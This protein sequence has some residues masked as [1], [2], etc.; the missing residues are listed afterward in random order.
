MWSPSQYD[1][2][3]SE[4]SQ[5]FFDLLDLVESRKP[6]RVVDLGC[7]TGDL[8][9]LLHERTEALHTLGID[10]SA[11]MLGKA[12]TDVPGLSFRQQSIAVLSPTDRYDLIFSNAAL[13]WLPNHETLFTKLAALLGPRGELAV[14]MPS[15]YGHPS[16]TVAAEV[17]R[18][19]RFASIL[20]GY[21]R[22]VDV[23]APTAYAALLHRLGFATQTV[24]LQVYGHVLESREG[25]VEWVKGTLLTDYSS[26]MSALDYDDFLAEYK[27]QLWERLSDERPYF[28]PFER[29]LLRARRL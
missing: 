20:H 24:R 22:P 14:Q 23:L 13:Q 4:R 5:P 26:K 1:K 8:T 29:V 16:H 21:V 28:Y 15:N 25:V 2:F 19:P 6:D 12:P 10:S 3:K 9:K 18:L 27:K 11:E 7:G 17:A